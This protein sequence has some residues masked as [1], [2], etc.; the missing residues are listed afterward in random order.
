MRYCSFLVL[1]MFCSVHVCG[2]TLAELEKDLDS[3]IRRTEKSN[4]VFSLGYGN[5]P[6]YDRKNNTYTDLVL[7]PYLSPG[8]TYFHKSG[9]N[10]GISTYYLFN[11][12]DKPWFEWD[13]SAGYDYTK[14]R[15]FVT[16]VN[17][18]KYLFTKSRE[19]IMP[20]PITNELFAYFVY[21]QWWLQPGIIADLGWG[22]EK[23]RLMR[24]RYSITHGQ[25]L[26]FIAS[27][28]H[29]FMFLDIA[30]RNDAVLITPSLNFIAGTANYYS[31]LESIQYLMQSEKGRKTIAPPPG[32]LTKQESR[33]IATAF[34]ARAVDVSVHLSYIIGRVSIV[35]SYTVFKL[36]TNTTDNG[37]S[38][39]FTAHVSV[40]L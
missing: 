33:D 9:L 28:R 16:G 5:N 13:L 2:Q 20:T 23:D 38:G 6:A 22:T 27:L 31:E 7:K 32:P 15:N 34:E 10:A 40:T 11:A 24:N 36:L 8:V 30:K 25:D 21:Q 4:V 37:I 39:Y 1:C 12:N 19:D 26:N 3:M 18:T 14:N 17:Y 29:D 35:P